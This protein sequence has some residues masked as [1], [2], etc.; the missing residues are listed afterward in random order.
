MDTLHKSEGPGGSE[1]RRMAD[2]IPNIV[3]VFSGARNVYVNPAATAI[4]GYTQDELM[5][6]DFWDIVHPE[7]RHLVKE[8]GLAR[9]RGE[10]VPREYEFKI[11]IS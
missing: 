5:A 10:S 7:Y 2:S 9:Q 4:T 1:F 8:R 3:V 6:M 11:N